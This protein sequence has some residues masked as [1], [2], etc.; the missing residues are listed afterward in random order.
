M[1]TAVKTCPA[2]FYGLHI[3][4]G[5][6][7]AIA[8]HWSYIPPLAALAF[9]AKSHRQTL[10]AL[11]TTAATFAYAK[12][13]YTFPQIPSQKAMGSGLF[14]IDSLS[15]QSSPFHRS[16]VYKG[17]LSSFTTTEGVTWKNIPCRIYPNLKK[18]RPKADSDFQVTGTLIE[19]GPQTYVLKPS[20]LTPI[21]KS[22]SFAETRFLAKEK[23]HTHLKTLIPD[24]QAC[25]F[26]TSMITGEIEER[27]LS[28]EFN[29][30][31]LQHI[32]G[33]SGFQFVLLASFVGF[34]LRL[35]F[36]YKIALVVLL[37]FLTS[38]FILLGNSP[39]VQRAWIAISV[40]LIGMLMNLRCTPLNALGVALIIEV[41][42]YPPVITHIGFQLSFLC[43]WAI[44]EVYP[45]MRKFFS[46]LLPIRTLDEV[47]KMNP[48]NQHGYIAVSLLRES[49]ALNLS[50][51]LIALPA[52]LSLFHKFPLLSLAYNLFFPFGAS[53]AFFLMLLALCFSIAFPPLGIALSYLCNTLT[54]GLLHLTSHP[55]VIA[56]ISIRVATFPL[57][58]AVV[59][60]T[61]LGF[62]TCFKRM[63]S[64]TAGPQLF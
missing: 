19:K 47:K 11:A 55:P 37:C 43:T 53:L 8:P 56:D 23:L 22:W 26:L 29:R 42:L 15:L 51:H 39:P 7:F 30:L 54:S 9:L 33:V 63:S 5:S 64:Q 44:L 3:L 58:F 1:K 17:T 60:L 35:I 61:L 16:Y 48:W 20:T 28:L 13:A 62:Y 6:A 36:P 12:T 45:L 50:V 24:K 18:G 14:N 57:S 40:F 4:I 21:E 2:F 46:Q 52:L 10:L 25:T 41:L 31:G 49:L 27:T 32:L 38:Y 34:I 59:F